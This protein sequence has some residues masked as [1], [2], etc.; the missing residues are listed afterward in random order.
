MAINEEGR[1]LP[2]ELKIDNIKNWEQMFQMVDDV[3]RWKD[4]EEI[5]DVDLWQ[6]GEI[7]ARKLSEIIFQRVINIGDW[8]L[9]R[10]KN[11]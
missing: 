4:W 7:G 5:P 8:K 1:P 9:I 10:R 6:D 11:G 2:D 3:E